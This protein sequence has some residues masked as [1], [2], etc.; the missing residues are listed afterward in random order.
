M[1]KA[2]AWS[3]VAGLTHLLAPTFAPGFYPTWYFALSAVAFGLML[4]AI[5]S[6]HV[7]HALVRQSGAIL[8]TITGASVVTLGSVAAAATGV[9]PAA[10]LVTGM[11]WWTI[12]KMWAETRV[13]PRAFGWLTMA[14]AIVCFALLGSYAYSG[15]VLMAVPDLP[16]RVILGGWL[17]VV[18]VLFWQDAGNMNR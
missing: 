1:R 12:G 13:L 10:F 15:G 5:A 7:R 14:L 4:P 16:L 8:G 2:A 11:W 17:V 9:V 18:A 6:L 3:L